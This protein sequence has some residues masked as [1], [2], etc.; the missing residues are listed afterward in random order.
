MSSASSPDMKLG[1]GHVLFVDIFAY[2]KSVLTEQR[3]ELQT[4]AAK[5]S[6][7]SSIS[8]TKEINQHPA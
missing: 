2:S 8:L 6:G 1:I 7:L 5:P 3:E 4:L